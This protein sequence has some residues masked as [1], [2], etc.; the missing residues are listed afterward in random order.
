MALAPLALRALH[1]L[2]QHDPEQPDWPDRDRFVLSAGHASMLLYSLL[3]L[4]GLRPDARRAQ[5]LPPAGQQDR[6]PPRVRPHRRG[7]GH[8]RPARPGHRERGRHGAGRA[9]ARRALQRRRPQLVDHHTFAIASDG[10]LKEGVSPRRLARRPPRP[11]EPDRVLRRQPHHDRGHTALAFSEDVG[12]RFEAY[13]WHVQNLGEDHDLDRIE[14]AIARGRRRRGPAALIVVRTHIA[15]GT[16][17]KQD[18]PRRTARRSAT[19]RSGSPRRPRLAARSRSSCPTR[20]SRT[21]AQCVERGDELDGGVDASAS[22]AY[23][24]RPRAAAEFERIARR[25][26]ARGWDA[27]VPQ[28]SPDAGDD[29]DAQ[30]LAAR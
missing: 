13:G 15:H 26:A 8:D 5:E 30:G 11:R 23:R 2:M 29:R 9:H 18:T 6:R 4:T 17:N 7:R 22:S 14:A 19:R 16:P 25:R 10:D 3:H 1:A 27:D 21:S 28:Q 20:C 12:A 24:G